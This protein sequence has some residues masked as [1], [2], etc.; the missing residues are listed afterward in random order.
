MENYLANRKLYIYSLIDFIKFS[1]INNLQA[2]CLICFF[3]FII[4]ILNITLSLSL[5]LLLKFRVVLLNCC[6]TLG[7]DS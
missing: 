7:F 5:L 4:I 3:V 1:R 2:Q 6:F